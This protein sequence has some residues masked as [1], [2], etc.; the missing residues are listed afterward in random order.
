MASPFT[1][2]RK[3]QKILIATLGMMAMIA[4]V[5]FGSQS[6][7]DSLFSGT[8]K[9]PVVV[10]TT[11]Y[12][13]ITR[14]HLRNLRGERRV[15]LSFLEQI[16]S[17]LRSVMLRTQEAA[18]AAGAEVDATD[19]AD[20]REKKQRDVDQLQRQAGRVY[21]LLQ[22]LQRERRYNT[23]QAVVDTW[24]YANRAEELG[25]TVSNDSINTYISQL[26]G[27]LIEKSTLQEI[28]RDIRVS[29]FQMFDILRKELLA[30]QLRTMFIYSLDGITP[31]QRWDYFQRFK[32]N[33]II[34]VVPIQVAD[35]VGETP[36][37]NE[38]TLLA[39]FKEYRDNYPPPTTP[40]PGFR[41]F[42]RIAVEYFTAD[43]DKLAGEISDDEIKERYLKD[44]EKYDELFR[45]PAEE[46]TPE[47]GDA[48]DATD[49]ADNATDGADNATDGAD[50]ATTGQPE[51]G[52]ASP[53]GTEEDAGDSGEVSPPMP[54][55]EQPEETSSTVTDSPF[56]VASYQE[57]PATEDVA[58]PPPIAPPALAG[59]TAAGADATPAEGTGGNEPPEAAAPVVDDPDQQPPAETPRRTPTEFEMLT[60]NVGQSIRQEL[61]TETIIKNFDAL[62]KQIK[63]YRGELLRYEPR[64]GA[65]P[66]PLD[67]K[68]LAEERDLT[69]TRTKLMTASEISKTPLGG[70]RVGST[71]FTQHAFS[72][73]QYEVNSSQASGKMYLFWKVD[74]TKLRPD[75]PEKGDKADHWH[76][77][78]EF[79]DSGVRKEVLRQWKMVQARDIALK[80][81]EELAKKVRDKDTMK[82]AFSEQ[83]DL[84]VI[85]TSPFTWMTL[86]YEAMQRVM[87]RLGR[88]VATSTFTRSIGNADPEG[89][90]I[91]N[92]GQPFMRKVFSMSEGEVGTAMNYSNEIVYLI[93]VENFDF[94]N[95]MDILID[96]DPVSQGEA[97]K[98]AKDNAWDNF[99][100]NNPPEPTY[101]SADAYYRDVAQFDKGEA[102]LAWREQLIEYAGLEWLE[103]AD[104]Y[105]DR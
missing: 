79:A 3:Y 96:T 6:L 35:Y 19:D 39:F 65:A 22:Q 90:G 38:E 15:L 44:K 71:P 26:T 103:P 75:E 105:A 55:N 99:L 67:L 50:D 104:R 36:E 86:D 76:G 93:R 29:S 95:R 30:R 64:K 72:G 77:I 92:L 74:E 56:R 57:D 42:P 83:P 102:F 46:T 73:G 54:E 14:I 28:F 2:F 32:R 58:E 62:K 101:L 25:H 4:F 94:R 1:I 12:G 52:D 20:L 68:R 91:D 24:L 45:P 84:I 69:F 33:A 23:D 8:A 21:M 85:R 40:D 47:E 43:L 97:R 7:M 37:P 48:T 16:T 88:L 53:D 78:L 100:A 34:D 81:A 10:T 41:K 13:D 63:A 11:Q 49:G 89:P 98:T 31:A 5:F 87:I 17:R 59:D 18:S 51:D 80:A 27:S 9:D 66:K 70:S 61:A 60:G 82:A